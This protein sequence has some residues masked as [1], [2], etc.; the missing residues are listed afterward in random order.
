MNEKEL[1]EKVERL[2]KENAVLK[3]RVQALW[4]ALQELAR[5]VDAHG[6]KLSNLDSTVNLVTNRLDDLRWGRDSASSI[7]V[8][9]RGYEPNWDEDW[10]E[11]GMSM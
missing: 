10:E 2:E 8:P 7:H 4:N 5:K 6:E 11:D 1:L 9:P 3:G